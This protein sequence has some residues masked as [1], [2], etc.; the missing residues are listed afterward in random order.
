MA[1]KKAKKKTKAKPQYEDKIPATDGTEID[2][3]D[4][5]AA[6]DRA[7]EKG[8]EGETPVRISPRRLNAMK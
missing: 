8:A 6:I 7:M 3:D 2:A 4:P 1:K 5:E